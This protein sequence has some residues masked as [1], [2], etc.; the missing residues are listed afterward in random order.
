MHRSPCAAACGR[1]TAGI[2]R[3]RDAAMRVNAAR[4]YLADDRRDVPG[5]AIG[6]GLGAGH[7]ALTHVVEARIAEH[8]TAS[9]SGLQCLARTLRDQRPFLLGE[10]RIEVQHERVGIG[11][12]LGDHERHL[13][14]HQ[15]GDE[16]HIARQPVELR[17][18]DGALALARLGE[19]R[20]EL[21]PAIQGV[22]ALAG[23]DLGELGGDGE[24]LGLGE[25]GDGRA[26]RLQ[27]KA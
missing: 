5:E 12:Q 15:A 7:C 14:R 17:D 4:L 21:W 2:E 24:A 25:R 9:L 27:A 13:V 18:G 26:L 3:P 23:L 1:N 22:R 8:N 20:D 16:M 6:F 11:A 10:R 19:R